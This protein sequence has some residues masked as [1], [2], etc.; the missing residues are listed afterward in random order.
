M[1]CVYCTVAMCG[2]RASL[3]HVQDRVNALRELEALLTRFFSGDST[4][5]EKLEISESCRAGCK[6]T[7]NEF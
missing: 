4:N 2:G 5:E 1:V 3:P 7:L 6:Q